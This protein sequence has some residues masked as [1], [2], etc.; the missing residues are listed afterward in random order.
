MLTESIFRYIL[1]LSLTILYGEILWQILSVTKVTSEKLLIIYGKT[2]VALGDKMKSS[3]LWQLSSCLL[4]NAPKADAKSRHQR[5]NQA[6]QQKN[7]PQAKAA[8]NN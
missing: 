8:K 1:A 3:G 2:P 4:A 5:L 6:Q 7:P